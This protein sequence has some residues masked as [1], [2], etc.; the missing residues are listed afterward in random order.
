MREQ[1]EGV[2]A[3]G[4][5][6]R[7]PITLG[8]AAQLIPTLR[9]E[10]GAVPETLEELKSAIKHQLRKM[11][12]LTASTAEKIDRM[13][14]GVVETGQQPICLGGSSLILNKIVYANCLAEMGGIVPLFFNVDYDGIKPELTNTRLPSLSPH[15]I[16]ISYPTE[17]DH[18]HRAIYAL[19]NP[20]ENWL[21]NTLEKIENNYKGLLKGTLDQNQLMQ[22]IRH[23]ISIIKSAFYTTE[24]VS[25]F[26]TKLIGTLVNIEGDLGVP[27]YWYSMPST[28]HLFQTGYETLFS[29]PN[30]SKFIEAT[31]K[32]AETVEASGYRSQ[33]GLRS[34]DYVPFYL[35]CTECTKT[36][37]ELKYARNHGSTIANVKGK[38]PKCGALHEY[39]FNA[40][41][42]DI[43][44]IIQNVSPRV[45]SRQIIVNSVVPVLARVGGLGETS[46]FA[47]VIPAAKALGL[48]VP[49]FMRYTRIFYNTPWNESLASSLERNG[50]TPLANKILFKALNKW[51]SAKNSGDG[52]R[53]AS[54]HKEIQYSIASSYKNLLKHLSNSNSEVDVIKQKLRDPGDRSILIKELRKKQI[55]SQEIKIYLSWAFG[56]FSAEK[57]GQEVNWNWLDLAGVAGLN[58][59]MGIYKR[60]Y[61][62]HTPNASMY[63]VNL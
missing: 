12:I 62:E 40:K 25:N 45:D 17:P 43:T 4:L 56:R 8:S 49:I 38:C 46:Y 15:G 54:A 37:V 11:G 13:H 21:R 51:V 30:R 31:N 41:N 32:A 28:R 5:W 55:V 19:E 16:A 39:S 61:N 6:N 2:V 14:E 60:L 26:Y 7:I 27:I 29:E 1:A 35:E 3:L 20:S 34:R 59:L 57:Y 44:D 47:E 52:Q 24:N 23:A 50:C 63:Y 9:A 48:P 53:L 42:P 22:N 18:E 10:Y 58:D 33:I 36:R